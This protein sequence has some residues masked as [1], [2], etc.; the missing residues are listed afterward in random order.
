MIAQFSE[1]A[2]LNEIQ[3]GQS[4]IADWSKVLIHNHAPDLFGLLEFDNDDIFLDPHVIALLSS[5]YF[6][7]ADAQTRMIMLGTLLFGFIDDPRK[8]ESIDV[9]TERDG[10]VYFPKIGYLF[11]QHPNTRFTFRYNGSLS[12]SQLTAGGK[13]VDM[14]R[15]EIIYVPGTSIEVCQTRPSFTESFY[16]A[17]QEDKLLLDANPPVEIPVELI[18]T[19]ARFQLEKAFAL[20][21][22]VGP[23]YASLVKQV[24]RKIQ[25]FVNPAI[26]NFATAS[27][28]GMIF[29]SVKEGD[30]E[31]FFFA[32]LIHQFGHCILY[33]LISQKKDYFKIDANTPMSALYGNPK[34]ARTLFSAYHGLYTTTKTS[35][36]LEI[37]IDQ[38]LFAGEQRLELLGRYIDNFRRFNTGLN[39]C[40]LPAILT[41]K[42]LRLY[43]E[44][45]SICRASLERKQSL[46][47]AYDVSN[48]RF[49]YDHKKFLKTNCAAL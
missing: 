45:E 5:A 34:D 29:L 32:E 30:D 26:R 24:A 28:R 18:R 40:D 31:V 10:S 17:W 7:R 33:E 22:R 47:S 15:S 2:V 35:Q 3:D 12:K 19:R 14:Q 42:G 44:L 8:P 36:Y 21:D 27:A 20:L 43:S 38:N 1:T 11:T 48:Q 16:Q 13:P 37:A 49:I 6:Q 25:L 46:V 9:I 41:E 39:K 4:R 23:S